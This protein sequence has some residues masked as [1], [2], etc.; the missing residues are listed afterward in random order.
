MGNASGHSTGLVPHS[1]L[2]SPLRRSLC[3][4]VVCL[5]LS[6]PQPRAGRQQRP[7]RPLQS[8]PAWLQQVRRWKLQ[9]YVAG[10]AGAVYGV[11]MWLWLALAVPEGI[12]VHPQTTESVHDGAQTVYGGRQEV[13]GMGVHRGMLEGGAAPV[14]SVT[15]IVMTM[16]PGATRAH[17]SSGAGLSCRA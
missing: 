15:L 6:W 17:W 5:S 1:L 7:P 4:H 13:A 2:Q 11:G 9:Q 3:V 10:S 14:Q 12:V 8:P 16:L